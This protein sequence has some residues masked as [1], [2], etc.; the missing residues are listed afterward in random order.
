M[1]K[2]Q[3]HYFRMHLLFSKLLLSKYLLK[4]FSTNQGDDRKSSGQV[5]EKT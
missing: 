1:F 2:F 5:E 3:Q 4:R